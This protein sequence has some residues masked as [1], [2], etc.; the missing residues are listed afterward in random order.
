M[1]AGKTPINKIYNIHHGTL[2]V[3]HNVYQKS[4]DELLE[5]NKDVNIHQNHFRIFALEV[6]KSLMHINPEFRE[7]YPLRGPGGHGLPPIQFLNQTRSNSFSF[8]HKG[9][10]FLWVFR[11]YSDQ[12]FNDFYRE[13]YNF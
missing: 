10:C 3:I 12:K 7:T 1:F 8:K 4:Y 13:C 2:Q 11:N 9:Y 6:F 5:I